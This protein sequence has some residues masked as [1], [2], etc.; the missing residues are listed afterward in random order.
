MSASVDYLLNKASAAQIAAH[1]HGCDGDFIPPL[2]TRVDLDDYAH[3]LSGK[4]TRFEAWSDNTLVGLVA[5]Y[6]NDQTQRVAYITS[7]SL[8]KPW[9]GQGVAARLVSQCIQHARDAGMHQISLEVAQD[10]EPALKLYAKHGFTTSRTNG[11]FIGM[12]LSLTRGADY[13]Q[14]T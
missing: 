6:C 9:S 8:L 3:K 1:L 12:N 14:Q 13:E 10:N 11:P 4:A 7:V 5:A 2:S